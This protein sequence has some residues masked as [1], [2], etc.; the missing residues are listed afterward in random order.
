MED[1]RA[2]CSRKVALARALLTSPTLLLLDEPTTGLDPRLQARGAWPSSKR[3][4]ASTTRRSLLV[5]HDMAEAE[6]LAARVGILDGGR[7]LALDH[8]GPPCGAA[9]TRRRSRTRSWAQPAAPSRRRGRRR[10]G[11]GVVMRFRAA[12]GR[13][14]F[15]GRGAGRPAQLTPVRHQAIAADER[16]RAQR[17]TRSKRYG[18]WESS[19]SSLWTVATR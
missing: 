17:N 14:S 12:A 11:G 4:A 2:G 7:L 9:T 18:W 13:S 16:R 15:S 5:H 8:A 19:R 3:S 1:C 6:A 10:R